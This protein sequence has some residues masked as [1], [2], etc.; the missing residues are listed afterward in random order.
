MLNRPAALVL[1]VTLLG[2][3]TPACVSS[4]ETGKTQANDSVQAVDTAIDAAVDVG[5]PDIALDLG[6]QVDTAQPGDTFVEPDGDTQ[7]PSWPTGAKLE[8]SHVTTNSLILTWPMATDDT[9]VTAYKIYRDG[10]LEKSLPS[11]KSKTMITELLEAETVSLSVVA[12]DDAGNISEALTISVQTGDETAPTWPE[13]SSLMATQTWDTGVFLSWTP[14]VDN[15]QV[16][17]Y[18]IMDGETV[19]RTIAGATLGD[20]PTLTPWTEYSLT[21]VAVDSVGNVS[22]PGPSI[23]FKTPDSQAPAW[24]EGAALNIEV[25]DATSLKIGWLPEVSDAGGLKTYKV[26]ENKVAVV[27]YIFLRFFFCKRRV[28]HNKYQVN[29]KKP[30]G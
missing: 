27:I 2:S 11:V 4:T 1:L 29:K 16:A 26:F 21:L 24:A 18:R 3:A 5:E 28:C 14:A 7:P 22:E 15:V 6:P 19:V 9:L 20:V 25:L 12:L 17:E 13:G 8:A 23:S 30:I 10:L